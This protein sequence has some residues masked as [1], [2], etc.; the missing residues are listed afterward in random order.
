VYALFALAGGP[1]RLKIAPEVQSKFRK[2]PRGLFCCPR[3]AAVA[4]PLRLWAYPWRQGGRRL[5]MGAVFVR[6]NSWA[7]WRFRRSKPGRFGRRSGRDGCVRIGRGIRFLPWCLQSGA[8]LVRH[9]SSP[10][11]RVV[12]RPQVSGL[13][14]MGGGEIGD[15]AAT[16]P[17][18]QG[19]AGGDRAAGSGVG[20]KTG[21]FT[22]HTSASRCVMSPPSHR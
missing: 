5:P 8:C 9:V 20:R 10:R 22:V 3:L 18:T 11:G 2:T 6:S 14:T 13:R 17:V 16:C 21:S 4:L 19:T 1:G 12:E 15:G 7:C